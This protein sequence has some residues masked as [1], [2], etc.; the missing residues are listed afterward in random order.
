[1]QATYLKQLST[2]SKHNFFPSKNGLYLEPFLPLT[3]LSFP[4][5]LTSCT[6]K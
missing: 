5:F 6:C 4:L 2:Y 3:S 1:M